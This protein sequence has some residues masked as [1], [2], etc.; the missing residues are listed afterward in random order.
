M[1]ERS[2]LASCINNIVLYVRLHVG[3]VM[4]D[5]RTIY[6]VCVRVAQRDPTSACTMA[7]ELSRVKCT[8]GTKLYACIKEHNTSFCHTDQW[9][10]DSGTNGT[11]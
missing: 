11:T 1:S 8:C 7:T 9:L 5:H 6:Y 4:H 10:S 3:V 2:K